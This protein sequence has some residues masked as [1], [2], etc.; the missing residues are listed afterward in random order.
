MKEVRKVPP[1]HKH[2][3]SIMMIRILSWNVNGLRAALKNG[4]EES[5]KQIDPDIIG[6]QEI[7]ATQEQVESDYPGAFAGYQS[8][9]N[10]AGRK[11]YSGTLLLTKLNPS[12]VKKGL[13]ISEFDSEGRVIISKFEN[14]PGGRP[15]TLF[16]IYYPNGQADSDRL[17]YKLRFYDSFLEYADKLKNSGEN[18]VIMGDFNTAHRDI[19]LKNPRENEDR[20]GFLPIEKE[21]IDKFIG[22]GYIDTFR[23]KNPDMEKYSWWT[24]RFG[25]RRR[26]IGWRID[27]VFVNESFFNSVLDSF[28]LNDV[29]GSDHCPVGITLR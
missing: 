26:N 2:K 14:V 9:W 7:K 3:R 1:E 12:S 17:D 6:F 8:V 28:I 11:G 4:L 24:Y 16:N 27:Y 23:A 22:H 20:S 13:G 19:D 25:A 21:W 29:E 10:P 15:F 5:L 18:L